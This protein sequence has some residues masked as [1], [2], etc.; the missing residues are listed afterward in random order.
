MRFFFNL[1]Q[2]ATKHRKMKSFYKKYILKN[3][4]VIFQKTLSPKK[5]RALFFFNK[6]A[7]FDFQFETCLIK[8]P[9]QAKK[10]KKFMNIRAQY[11]IS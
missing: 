7:K 4:S 1:F 3:D 11:N 6:K 2:V 5:N 10:K 9:S 8:K